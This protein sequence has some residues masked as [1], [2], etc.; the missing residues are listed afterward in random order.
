MARDQQKTQKGQGLPNFTEDE[1]R[2]Y[3]EKIRW[4]D[5]PFCPHCA[6][7]N[8]YRMQGETIRKGLLACRDCRGHFTV[9]VG[10]VMEDSHLPLSVWVRAFH[11]MAS[12]K[13]GISALQLQRNLGIGVSIGPHGILPTVSVKQ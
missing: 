12:S 7:V 4:P 5:G 6:S 10:T 9:T 8:V 1:A 13:K 2:E 11:L 3:I